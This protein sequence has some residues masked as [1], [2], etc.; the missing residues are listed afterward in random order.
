MP[1]RRNL[2][3]GLFSALLLQ[4]SA[5]F[6][7]AF[8]DANQALLDGDVENGLASM[9]ALAE[10]GD[11]LMQY[12]VGVALINFS[13][14]DGIRWISTAADRNYAE[15]QREI[16]T[17]YAHGIGVH[18][19]LPSAFKWLY[20]AQDNKL[21]KASRKETRRLARQVFAEMSVR[22]RYSAKQMIRYWVPR[23]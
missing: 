16:G 18:R 23:Q 1:M 2:L 7:D 20:L 21:D 12:K 9:N 13:T 6:A 14:D 11:P 8:D 5:A 15:A 19:D 22:E 3:A 10:S 17:L 4:A